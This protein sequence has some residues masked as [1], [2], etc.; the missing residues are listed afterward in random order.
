MVVFLVSWRQPCLTQSLG[1]AGEGA[2]EDGGQEMFGDLLASGSLAEFR[3]MG[4]AAIPAQTVPP[5]FLEVR[6]LCSGSP[7]GASVDFLSP[8]GMKRR[9]GVAVPLGV[10]PS[11]ELLSIGKTCPALY[12]LRCGLTQH[13]GASCFGTVEDSEDCQ[14]RLGSGFLWPLSRH[15]VSELPS[16]STSLPFTGP[17]RS[18]CHRRPSS[19]ALTHLVLKLTPDPEAGPKEPLQANN[20]GGEGRKQ[21]RGAGARR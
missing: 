18:L 19:P 2:P 21:G 6:H 20:E 14:T 9:L 11:T 16:L 4:F 7:H 1:S 12:T 8:V 10:G 15:T 5:P 13:L 3:T 17:F